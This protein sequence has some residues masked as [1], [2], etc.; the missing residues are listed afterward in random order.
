MTADSPDLG[1]K[2]LSKVVEMS[3]T[4]QL[5]E[6]EDINVDIRTDPGKLF[7]GKVDSVEISGKGLVM[8]QDLRMET[9][10]VSTD[11]VAINPLG[12]VFGNVEL[13]HPTEAEAEIVLNEADIN[14]AFNSDFI[15]DKLKNLPINVDG[16]PNVAHV[17]Q[18]V[19]TLP[20][21]N[22]FAIASEFNLDAQDQIK[23][24]AAT[25]VPKVDASGQKIDLEILSAEGE[26]LNQDL[27]LSI[28]EQ[29]TTLLDLR[30]FDLPGMSLQLEKLE[31]QKG[32]L[33][34][35]ARTQI[36]QIPSV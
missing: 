10:A 14:H 2:A 6:V 35:H 7:Q 34:I 18:V 33:V 28:F 1:E 12:V 25:A 23:K 36:H 17:Q 31:A 9:I 27:V 32:R 5:D 8:K 26:G 19:I 24:L 16:Q 11:Q 22:K 15:Q 13:T 3:I 20:G 30:N 29:L 21:D 4:S